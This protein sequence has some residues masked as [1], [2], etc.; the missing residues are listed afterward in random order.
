MS[1]QQGTPCTDGDSRDL[2]LIENILAKLDPCA[3]PREAP[4]PAPD[5]SSLRKSTRASVA[6]PSATCAVKRPLCHCAVKRQAVRFGTGLCLIP[7]RRF[8]SPLSATTHCRPTPPPSVTF[9]PPAH[10]TTW[11]QDPL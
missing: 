2:L 8:A 3:R 11:S 6:P 1:A 5:L 4:P 9:R 10:T 7:S